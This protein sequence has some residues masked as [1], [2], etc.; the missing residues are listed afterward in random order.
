MPLHQ[1]GKCFLVAM[2]HKEVQELTIAA[3]HPRDFGNAAVSQD[4]QNRAGHSLSPAE[5]TSYPLLPEGSEFD[6]SLV[7]IT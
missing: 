5:C 3:V 2:A 1:H 6:T 4:L 7:E